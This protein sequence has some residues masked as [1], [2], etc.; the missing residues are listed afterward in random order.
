[1]KKTREVRERKKGDG[2][3]IPSL[4]LF[5]GPQQVIW[6]WVG[7]VCSNTYIHP[8]SH[9]VSALDMCMLFGHT[10]GTCAILLFPPALYPPS[11]S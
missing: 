7:T 2:I 8:V 9:V 1:M 3:N 10:L 5:Q 11:S 4:V 6:T